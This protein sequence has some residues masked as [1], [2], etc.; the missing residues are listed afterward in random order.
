MVE[1]DLLALYCAAFSRHAAAEKEV[2]VSGTIIKSTA[3]VPMQNPYLAVSNT[4]MAQVN[5]YG[6]RLRIIREKKTKSVQPAAA[7]P[8]ADLPPAAGRDDMVYLQ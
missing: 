8:L 5:R 6:A 7:D 1:L 4:A 3:G 2:T